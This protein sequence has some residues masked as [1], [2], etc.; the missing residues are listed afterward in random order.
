MKIRT[1]SIK[2]KL[3]MVILS[4]TSVALV[5]AFTISLLTSIRRLKNDMIDDTLLLTDYISESAIS[6]LLFNDKTGGRDILSKTS[7]IEWIHQVIIYDA[8]GNEFTRYSRREHGNT[9]PL[10]NEPDIRMFIDDHLY[11][12][13]AITYM[14]EDLGRILVIASTDKLNKKLHPS[15]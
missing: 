5:T 10:V 6:P 14:E 15:L 8:E 11:V 13:K 1:L 2:D 7:I 12:S 9:P 4:V 3:V